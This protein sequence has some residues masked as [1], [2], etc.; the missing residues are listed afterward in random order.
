MTSLST[1]FWFAQGDCGCSVTDSPSDV[2]ISSLCCAFFLFIFFFLTD[3]LHRYFT[4]S[5]AHSG[6]QTL[7]SSS[8]SPRPHYYTL[9]PLPYLTFLPALENPP[10]RSLQSPPQSHTTIDEQDS[11]FLDDNWIRN[12]MLIGQATGAN[13]DPS[14]DNLAETAAYCTCILLPNKWI[15]DDIA[16][17]LS[18]DPSAGPL[19]REWTFFKPVVSN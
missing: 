17:A 8:T 7:A 1:D 13:S 14:E 18:S 3:L 6:L 12:I 10:L 5:Y 11:R 2:F 19:Y 4:P 15:F 16:L 9:C